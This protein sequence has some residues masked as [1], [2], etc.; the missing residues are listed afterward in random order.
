MA[1][2]RTTVFDLG[3]ST[4]GCG[5]Y[6]IGNQ[7]KIPYIVGYRATCEAYGKGCNLSIERGD[8]P[9]MPRFLIRTEDGYT[10]SGSSPSSPFAKYALALGRLDMVNG[11]EAYGLTSPLVV[12]LLRS[13]IASSDLKDELDKEVVQ[14]E[15]TAEKPSPTADQN[16]LQQLRHLLQQNQRWW[17]DVQSGKQSSRIQKAPSTAPSL[18]GWLDN[19]AV[20]TPP[21]TAP[22]KRVSSKDIPPAAHAALLSSRPPSR[23][24]RRPAS[25]E[26]L[27][28]GRGWTAFTA[29]GLETRDHV[30]AE[31]PRATAAEIEKIV[32]Q[33]WAQLPQEE[34]QHFIDVAAAVRLSSA[35]ANRAAAELDLDNASGGLRRARSDSL[36][37]KR[38]VKRPKYYNQD[39]VNWSTPPK[40]NDEEDVLGLLATMRA[41]VIASESDEH[42]KVTP[43]VSDEAESNIEKS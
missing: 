39:F 30:R 37:D 23:S 43:R 11:M 10:F 24:R 18:Q 17:A 33:K 40:G 36:G 31:N 34:K 20:S 8:S 7:K 29:F 2:H 15:S 27:K 1:A 6:I 12:S 19:T 28:S 41:E 5:W 32:G 26:G 21:S 22:L 38:A 9:S 16:H 3:D 42:A 13:S 35:P 25:A 4:R 14:L